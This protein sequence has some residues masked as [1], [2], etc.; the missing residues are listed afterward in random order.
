MSLKDYIFKVTLI[1]VTMLWP[2]T[3]MKIYIEET[4][5]EDLSVELFKAIREGEDN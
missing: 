1:Q 2:L 3:S 5:V 4:L